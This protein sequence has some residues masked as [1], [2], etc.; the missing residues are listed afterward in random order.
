MQKTW[1]QRNNACGCGPVL[2]Y[3]TEERTQIQGV[4]GLEPAKIRQAWRQ[5]TEGLVCYGKGYSF[6]LCYS[7]AAVTEVGAKGSTWLPLKG[8]LGGYI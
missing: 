6:G 5:V 3:V 4:C 7:L 8:V 1:K 2:M